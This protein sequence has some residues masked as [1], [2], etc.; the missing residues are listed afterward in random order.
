MKKIFLIDNADSIAEFFTDFLSLKGYKIEVSENVEDFSKRLDYFDP[1]LVIF[2]TDMPRSESYKFTTL[3]SKN[4]RIRYKPAL[5]LT[6]FV[7]EAKIKGFEEIENYEFMDKSSTNSQIL[8]RIESLLKYTHPES[9]GF[10]R[11][12][13]LA[14]VPGLSN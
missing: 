6:G 3:K 7:N 14:E 1:D 5:L 10:Y 9:N 11:S 13:G 8:R 2:D 4:P 12:R